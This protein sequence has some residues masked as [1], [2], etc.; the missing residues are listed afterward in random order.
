MVIGSPVLFSNNPPALQVNVGLIAAVVVIV[1]ALIVL[2]I[3]AIVRGQRRRVTTGE[4]GLVGKVAVA[5]T[6]LNPKG[7]VLVEG[8]LWSASVGEGRVEPEEEVIVAKVEGL[9]LIV[10]RKKN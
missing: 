2:V 3:L 10:T 5:K 4:E 6:E 8:E 9:K 1:A 7:T